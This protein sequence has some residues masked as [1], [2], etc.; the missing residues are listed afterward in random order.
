M[1]NEGIHLGGG[2]F[3]VRI[4]KCAFVLMFS[5]SLILLASAC[6]QPGLTTSS[7]ALLTSTPSSGLETEETSTAKATLPP[8]E[9]TTA[10][11]TAEPAATTATTA[12]ETTAAPTPTKAPAA[13]T[14]VPTTNATTSASP[15]ESDRIHRDAFVIDTHCDTLLDI[16][17]SDTWLPVTNLGRST[18]FMVD[19]P[20]LQAG[21]VDVQ[22]FAAYTSGYALVGGG[23]D[24]AMANC[25]LLSIIN[26]L[27][28]TVAKNTGTTRQIYSLRDIDQMDLGGRIGILAS[29]EGAYSLNQDNGIELLR[30]YCDLGVRMVAPTWNYSNALGEGV[31][32]KYRDGTLSTGG[33]TE[34][35][36][37][38]IREMNKLGIAV[39][40][41]HLNE[42][43][44]WDVAAVTD[45][46]II[47]SHSCVYR[48]NPN[49][50]NLKDNQIQAIADSGGVV[51]VCFHRPFLAADP[52]MATIGTLVDHIE[53]VAN[54]VGIDHVGLGSDFDGGKMPAGL[55]N[56]SM[57][58][59]I[60]RE[61]FRRGHSET[62]IRKI[63]GGNTARA[64]NTIWDKASVFFNSS[65]APKIDLSLTSG[66]ILTSDMPAL[67]AVISADEGFELDA[68]SL[69]AI[70]DGRVL[71]PGFDAGTGSASLTPSDPLAKKFHVITFTAANIS[72][73]TARKTCIFYIQ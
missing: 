52:D 15:S 30:Q 72:G 42:A 57:L 8:A 58:P 32:E 59:N 7:S 14:A 46:P 73:E 70:L 67:T 47:A 25:R 11:T 48:L 35:G 31:S 43:T 38:V 26:G 10:P 27:K 71:T 3:K 50:R 63:L 22:V 2:A 44:F 61:L 60:T 6:G 16:D 69:Q 18:S 55:T 40:V 20:K 65:H 49:V 68:A 12:A 62:E 34:L 37:S 23:Q 29:I 54:L 17:N 45:C 21:G 13:S 64:L 41:S 28:W 33:L 24:F 5:I 39:D 9:M 1:Y 66:A 4:W 36:E 19:I 56:A 51:Q 53:Y